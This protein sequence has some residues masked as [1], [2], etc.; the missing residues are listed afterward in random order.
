MWL[1]KRPNL[2]LST[3]SRG[4]TLA[5]PFTTALRLLG[6]VVRAGW[7]LLARSLS[8]DACVACD[9]EVDARAVFCRACARTV[10]RTRT[11]MIPHPGL[12]AFAEFGEA[13]AQ[14]I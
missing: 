5:T 7:A 12:V 4:G 1:R 14:A 10:Q 2:P 8:P 13:L 11:G 9:A 3:E 6:L